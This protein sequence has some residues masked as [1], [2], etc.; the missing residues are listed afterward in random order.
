MKKLAVVLLQFLLPLSTFAA[1]Y[2]VTQS[3][4]GSQ[5]GTSLANAWSLATF[6]KSTTPTGGDTVFFSG[7]FTS[8]VTPAANGTSSAQL[9]LD[10]GTNKATIGAY[11]GFYSNS[12]LTV[13]GGTIATNAPGG[14]DNG[15]MDFVS[16]QSQYITIN[17]WTWTGQPGP[18][19]G[20]LDFVDIWANG[21]CSNLTISNNNLDNICHLCTSGG[22]G[23]SNNGTVINNYA[24]TSTN[25]LLQTDVI[26]ISNATNWLIQGN[27]LVNQAPGN[28]TSPGDNPRHNDIIQTYNG[29]GGHVIRYN[30][31]EQADSL[32]DGS[33]SWTMIESLSGT[34]SVYSNVFVGSGTQGNNGQDSNSNASSCTFYCYNNTYIRLSTDANSTI[35]F[36]NSGDVY[37]RN[38]AMQWVINNQTVSFDT[39]MTPGAPLDYNWFYNTTAPDQ[40][41][42][43]THG[44]MTQNLMF[45]ALGSAVNG[46]PTGGNQATGCDFSTQPGSPLRNAGDSTIGSQYAWGIAPGATWPNP[47]LN[48]RSAGN[49]DVGAYQSNTGTAGGPQ[50]PLAP[51]NLRAVTGS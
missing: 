49:W 27:K 51:Q 19:G 15:I 14:P 17:G 5:N 23:N 1:S 25:T 42:T 13:N 18:N 32:G 29:G 33:N 34:I 41:V 40:S 9:V 38:N 35:R 11:I 12:Y 46:N 10:F 31:L 3:G 43:A 20:G 2:Y 44:S 21:I 22:S 30:W 39:Q 36:Q 50:A 45:N 48:P 24:R 26:D 16:G 8:G 6:N 47:T 28:Q 7:T 37:F 4:A